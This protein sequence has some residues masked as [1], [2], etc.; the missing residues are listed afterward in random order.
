MYS[1]Q[2]QARV[3]RIEAMNIEQEALLIDPGL[4]ADI[5]TSTEGVVARAGGRWRQMGISYKEAIT[6]MTLTVPVSPSR[7]KCR[8]P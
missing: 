5:I 4:A 7:E 1:K 3:K 6:Y 2:K 8:N